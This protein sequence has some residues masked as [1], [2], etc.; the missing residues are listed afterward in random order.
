LQQELFRR[1]RPFDGLAAALGDAVDAAEQGHDGDALLGM[2]EPRALTREND[3]G[4]HRKFETA[5]KAQ[6]LH[7]GD[8][9]NGQPFELIEATHL[10]LEQ[11]ASLALRRLWPGDDIAAETEV[12]TLGSEQ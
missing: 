8:S 7:R 11:R 4:A 6:S 1:K 3:I 12:R 5:A 10:V 2:A 9:R